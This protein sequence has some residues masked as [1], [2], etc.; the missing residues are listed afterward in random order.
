MAVTDLMLFP[1]YF[2]GID[3]FR[4]VSCFDGVLSGSNIDL[5]PGFIADRILRG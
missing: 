1:H 4:S 5:D 2:S 3:I